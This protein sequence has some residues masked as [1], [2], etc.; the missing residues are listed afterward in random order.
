MAKNEK[1]IK[2]KILNQVDNPSGRVPFK[3]VRKVDIGY[4]KTKKTIK[5]CIL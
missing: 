3:D 1:N 4:F 5:K 2:I